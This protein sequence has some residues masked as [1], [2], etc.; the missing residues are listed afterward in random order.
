MSLEICPESL[1]ERL[2]Q[3]DAT[4]TFYQTPIWHRI[5]ARHYHAESA[6]L[7]FRLGNDGNTEA[8]LPLL[9]KRRW[10]RDVYFSPFGTYSALICSRQ[11]APEELEA[12]ALK[13][14]RLNIHLVSSPFAKNVVTVGTPLETK[15]QVIDL[16][17]M[18]A[19][20]PMRDWEPDQRRRALLAQKNGVIVKEAT[21]PEEW[22]RYYALYEISI[23]RWGE[24]A[25][26]VY[27][28]SLFEDIR[29]S[30]SGSSSMRLWLAEHNGEIGGGCLVFYHNGWAMYW[31]GA[32]DQRF[33]ALGTTQLLYL[34]MIQD[35]LS[36][37]F[38]VLD[39]MGSAGLEKLEAFKGKFGA[40]TV[41]FTSS[42]NRTG[43]A[44]F[45]AG[46]LHR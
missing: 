16:T 30:L 8:C 12:I 46:L 40:R 43:F 25:T 14:K 18:D 15:T 34:T 39:L 38:S 35:A 44:R 23:R 42:V 27:P 3:E 29:C 19:E 28:A 13:L 17:S 45:A 41:E 4:C 7:L 5:A 1:W 37:N 21:S 2:C 10:G 20:N 6:P 9:K 33:F 31:H 11:L 32:S 24:K 36:R 22:K 26:G